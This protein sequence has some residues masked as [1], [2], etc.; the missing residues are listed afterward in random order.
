MIPTVKKVAAMTG[1]PKV[2]EL[3]ALEGIRELHFLSSMDSQ[4]HTIAFARMFDTIC[5]CCFGA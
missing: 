5:G 3:F 2:Q 1:S 4:I